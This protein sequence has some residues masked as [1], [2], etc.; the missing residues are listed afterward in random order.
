[1]DRRLTFLL[2]ALSLAACSGESSIQD[3]NAEQ[4]E[5]LNAIAANTS[6]DAGSDMAQNAAKTDD[7]GQAYRAGA[8]A[9]P[10]HYR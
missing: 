9:P 3:V 8:S 4:A 1:M 7:I 10:R 5:Q 2:A 6:E